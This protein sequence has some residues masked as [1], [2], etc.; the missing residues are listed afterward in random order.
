MATV[1]SKEGTTIAFDKVGSGRA[2][3]LINGAI[4]G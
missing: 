3:S 1:T 2:V 4:E